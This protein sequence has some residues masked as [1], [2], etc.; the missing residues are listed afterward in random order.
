[1]DIIEEKIKELL[2]EAKTLLKNKRISETVEK[3][4][5]VLQLD[6]ENEEAK[7]VLDKLNIATGIQIAP[8]RKLLII[9]NEQE[10]ISNIKVLFNGI[11]IGQ[12]K[13]GYFEFPLK[14]DGIVE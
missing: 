12:L 13:N 7:Y 5:Q 3:I 1:M 10:T 11:E 2:A 6:P 14:N 9:S 4:K 8:T